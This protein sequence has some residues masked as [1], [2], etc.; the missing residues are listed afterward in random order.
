MILASLILPVL[1]EET[2]LPSL[3]TALQP[4]RSAG[5]EVI[6]VDGGSQD[7]TCKL[8]LGQVDQLLQAPPGRAGQM[9]LGA[10]AA[11]GPWLFFL[12]ADTSLTP[13]A[14]D[15]LL[16][17][18]AGE[19]AAWGRF[20]VCILGQARLLR[21]VALLMN[22]RSRWTGIATGDQLIFMHQALFHAL[23]GYPEQPLMEDIEISKRL[24]KM[25][26]PWCLREK[27][28]T[29][30]RRWEQKGLWRTIFLMWRLR[31]RYWRGTPARELVKAYYP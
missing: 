4:L 2:T 16:Q 24:K 27:V 21:L 23:G 5:V 3:L 9:N 30:G 6:L 13:E 1:N 20:D 14:S 8:A 12:H 11:Q 17:V 29:S 15:R 19:E 7:A 26:R 28:L 22:L 10:Q 31:W 25:Q 18:A